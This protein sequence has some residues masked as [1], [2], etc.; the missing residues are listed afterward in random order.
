MTRNFDP[1]KQNDFDSKTTE[2]DW[3]SYLPI[4]SQ[5]SIELNKL[6]KSYKKLQTQNKALEKMLLYSES[7]INKL[8]YT[9]KRTNNILVHLTRALCKLDLTKPTISK[10]LLK[11][12]EIVESNNE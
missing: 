12:L 9:N 8:Q 5:E 7:V 11:H 1:I 3:S 6:K 10:L 2:M 4:V